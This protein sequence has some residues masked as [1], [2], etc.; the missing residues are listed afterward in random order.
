M[1][2]AGIHVT[3][4]KIKDWPVHTLVRKVNP[5][6]KPRLNPK[7]KVNP[8]WTQDFKNQ[9]PSIPKIHPESKPGV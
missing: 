4:I 1:Q 2:G 3:G 7:T 9:T 5:K 8:D 6:S